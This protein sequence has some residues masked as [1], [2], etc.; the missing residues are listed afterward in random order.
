MCNHC[1]AIERCSHCGFVFDEDGECECVPED[2]IKPG[3]QALMYVNAYSVTRHYGGPEEGGWWFNANEPLASIPIKATSQPGHDDICYQCH[4][5]RM[6]T[7]DD[8]LEPIK[9]CKWGFHLV[10]E[11]PEQVEDFKQHLQEIYA[12][13]DDGNIYSVCGGSELHVVIEDHPGERQPQSKPRYE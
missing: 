6:G 10:T 5:A 2:Y 13:V 8:N 3:T 9:M 11:S 12:D 7:L 4:R 1:E